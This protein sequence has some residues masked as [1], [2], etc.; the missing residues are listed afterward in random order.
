[1]VTIDTLDA[2]TIT[3]PGNGAMNQ[4]PQATRAELTRQV[5]AMGTQALDLLRRF[6][7]EQISAE[8]L[9][10]RLPELGA[11]SVLAEYWGLLIGEPAY[12]ACFEVLQLLSTL[13]SEIGYQLLHYGPTSLFED[14][15]ELELAVKRLKT[16]TT[17]DRRPTTADC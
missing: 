4:T 8:E 1:M 2:T 6:G 5:L 10:T 14:F 12:A 16:M 3:R 7:R 11:R 17:D 9:V 15:K 13:E